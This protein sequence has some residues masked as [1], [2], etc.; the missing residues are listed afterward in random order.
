M[1][2]EI[3]LTEKNAR[4]LSMLQKLDSEISDVVATATHVAGILCLKILIFSPY[5]LI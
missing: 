1:T 3:D 2:L 4:N 5:F